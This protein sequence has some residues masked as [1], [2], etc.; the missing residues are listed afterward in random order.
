MDDFFSDW[1]CL[2][3][4]VRSM[5]QTNCNLEI[6]WY[7]NLKIKDKSR[8]LRSKNYNSLPTGQRLSYTGELFFRK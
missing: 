8:Y 6:E 2:N 3:C 7:E 4:L 1:P 5:C